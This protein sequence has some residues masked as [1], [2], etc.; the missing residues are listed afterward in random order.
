MSEGVQQP[1]R[2]STLLRLFA[3][4]LAGGLGA[5]GV[6]V[7]GA[8]PSPPPAV[9]QTPPPASAPDAPLS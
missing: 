7:A 4:A 1:S 6:P 2:R 8:H 5:F 3:A 9:A